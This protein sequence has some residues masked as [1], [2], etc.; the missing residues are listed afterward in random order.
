MQ[1]PDEVRVAHALGRADQF[2]YSNTLEALEQSYEKGFRWFEVD[3]AFTVDGDLVCFH[4]RYEH[5]I[6]LEGRL[7]DE[8]T[9]DDF[10]SR[11][12]KES[13]T[14]MTF[15]QLLEQMLERPDLVLVTDTKDMSR[16]VLAALERDI[17]A[18]DEGLRTRV[19]LQMY[20]AEQLPLILEAEADNGRFGGSSSPSTWRPSPIRSS[21]PL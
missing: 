9:T 16:E 2:T 11:K 12:W 15:R 4:E 6:A 19:V 13:Y 21:S 1:P 3:L 8:I 20:H 10:L 14:L 17:S 18:V 7:V 5:N